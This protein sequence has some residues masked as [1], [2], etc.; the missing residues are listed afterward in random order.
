MRTNY[1]FE[2]MHFQETRHLTHADKL[3]SRTNAFPGD[4]PSDKCQ[5]T[6]V[7]DECISKRHAV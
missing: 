1:G 2:Q 3:W 4:T 5:Q 6:L 7:M